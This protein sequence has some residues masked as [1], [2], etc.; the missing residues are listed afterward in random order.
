MPTLNRRDFLKALG[1]TGGASALSA[2]GID[3]NQY[4]T[5]VERILPYVVKPEQVTPGTYTFFGTSVTRGPAA[6]PVTARHR[7]GRVTFVSANFGTPESKA[8]TSPS[9]PPAAMFELQKHYSPDRLK[10]PSEGGQAI[11]WKGGQEKLAAAVQS[12]VAAGKKV[13]Y[14]GGYKGGAIVDLI[15]DFTGGSAVFW[16][17]D[18]YAADAKASE[19]LFGKR[20]LPFYALDKADYVLSF[21]APFLSG[22]GD[23]DIEARFSKARNPNIDAR[24]ARFALVA[25]VRDQTGAKADDFLACAPGSEVAVARAIAALVAEKKGASDA[26]KSLIGAASVADAATASGLTAEQITAVAESIVAHEAVA[27]PG[28]FTGSTDLAVATWLIN[29]ASGAAGTRV[30]LGGFSGPIAGYDAV[31]AL[32]DDMASDRVGVLI[33]DDVNPVYALPASAG[34]EAALGKVGTVVSVTSHGDETSKLAKLSLPVADVFEDWGDEAPVAGLRVLRQPAMSPLYDAVSFGDLLLTVARAAGLATPPS[35]GLGYEPATWRAYLAAWW[36]RNVHTPEDPAFDAFWEKSLVAGFAARPVGDLTPALTAAAYAFSAT[37]TVGAGEYFLHVQSHPFRRDGRYAN[38]PWAQEVPD[39]MTGQVWDSWLEISQELADKLGV[40]YN[41][42][43][44]VSTDAG[45]VEVAV[46]VFKHGR[47]D[48]AALALGQ[49]HSARGRY[50]NGY[51]VNAFSVLPLAK[52]GQ[53]AVPWAPTKASIRALGRQGD[54]VTAFSVF[55]TSD[56]DRNFGVSVAAE[57]LAKVGDAA[58]AHPG[59]LTGIA[60]PPM[61]KRLTEQGISDFYGLPDHPT[62][63]FGLTVDTNACSGCGA[64]S[65]ACYAENNLP[66]VGKKQVGKGREM[67][68]VR[69]N[70][71]IEEDGDIHF[72]PLMCQHCGHA[73]CENVCPVLA[74]YHTIDG[75]NAMVYNRCV[76]TRYCSNACPYSARKFNYHTFTWPEPFNLQLNPDVMVREMG[77]MEK[78][79]FCVQRIRQVKSA[80]RSGGNFTRTVPNEALEQLPACVEACPSQAL[81]FGNLKDEQSVVA[82]SRK[83]ARSYELLPDLNFFPAINYLAKASFHHDPTLH[84][85]GGHGDGEHASGAAAAGDHHEAEAPAAPAH[86]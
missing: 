66:V 74:T 62:Y 82:S 63:R 16:E 41:D 24:V 48:V 54:L 38:E 45:K 69:I 5:P 46:H 60:H 78:C 9:V 53:G 44:E 50:S 3:T 10:G 49:G 11:D 34:F 76:G 13:A 19:L 36:Q 31:Q 51:G 77:V 8:L 68:W 39:P 25:P 14:F 23:A 73:G 30:T 33:L 64:C 55:G 21:G 81:T 79:T 2:C 37:T 71:Y 61:D 7:D 35:G 32:I 59:E 28:G 85:G 15:T 1:I 56:M 47:G 83:S 20:V 52:D 72:V 86:H 43:V 42:M 67:G 26:L 17:A 22:W 29:L 40:S 18:G 6:H 27:L 80:Y 70:R 57:K 4:L 65:I 12:A 58:A 75:L 84:H